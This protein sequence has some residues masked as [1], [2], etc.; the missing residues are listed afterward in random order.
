MSGGKTGGTGQMEEGRPE[1]LSELVREVKSREGAGEGERASKQCLKLCCL[2]I[3]TSFVCRCGG[4]LPLSARG[5]RKRRGA[6][7]E[8]GN[9]RERDRPP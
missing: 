5:L 8:G 7:T 2:R 6:E 3:L 1:G 4:R 9:Q